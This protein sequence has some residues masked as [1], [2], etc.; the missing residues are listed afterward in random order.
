V[1]RNAPS[2]VVDVVEPGDDVGVA[3]DEVDAADD[4]VGPAEVEEAPPPV[5]WPQPATR[6]VA[7]AAAAS[8]AEAVDILPV[9]FTP[10][11]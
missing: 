8:R 11:R 2:T 3:D 5:A 9:R 10:A 6:I 1:A 4:E 7:R